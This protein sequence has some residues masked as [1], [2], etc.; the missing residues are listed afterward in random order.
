MHLPSYTEEQFI[1]LSVKVLPKLKIAP[2]IG[3]AVWNQR[4]DIRNVTSI[5]KLVRKNDGLE[6]VEQIFTM[7]TKYRDERALNYTVLTNSLLDVGH[8][9]FHALPDDCV[10]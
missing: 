10:N 9:Y 7:M 6:E 4:G 3:K 8:P 1:E 2:I 5:G